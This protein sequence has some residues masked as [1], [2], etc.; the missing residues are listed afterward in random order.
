MNSNT[1]LS[2]INTS[3]NAGT[4]TL[5][6]IS[7]VPGR[8]I[9]FKDTVGTF[10]TKTL[11]LNTSG[12]DTFEDGG[13]TKVLRESY[14]SIQLVGNSGKWYIL[15]GTQV[16]TLQLS[17]LNAIAISTINLST[18]NT[19]ISSLNF[20]DNRVSTNTLYGVI[21]SVSTQGVST[22]FLYY[23]NFVIAGTRVGYSNRMNPSNF[24]VY[25]IPNLS[26]WI[27]SSDKSSF[28]VS[29]SNVT[30]V[31]DKSLNKVILSGTTGFSYNSNLN[32][33]NTSY[34]SFYNPTANNATLGYNT[35]F[36]ATTPIT[37][38]FVGNKITTTTGYVCDASPNY[39]NS[40]FN[41]GTVNREFLYNG[42]A[43]T[44]FGNTGATNI[45]TSN[46]LISAIFA[47]NSASALYNNGTLQYSGSVTINS[48]GITLGTRY[49]LAE[50]FDG[51]YCEFMLFNIALNTFQR[52]Q[53][54]GYLA[55]KWGLQANLPANHP[56][57]NAPP[58]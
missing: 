3:A 10:G 51:N 9:S 43:T 41:N 1:E 31:L 42:N 46:P 55:W 38:F 27:D 13:T 19:K 20:I 39:T 58:Q 36:N 6:L 14:G 40:P 45:M 48:V 16:N 12:S 15:N 33:F 4:V 47:P 32:L 18:I 5:P 29:G 22:N 8:V 35:S 57:K 30:K 44:L 50:A 7:T 34:P 2:L 23:N 11:T 25:S 53:I 28:T 17:T 56:F 49:S 26:L 37:I 54:E 52:Q 21:S 24:S